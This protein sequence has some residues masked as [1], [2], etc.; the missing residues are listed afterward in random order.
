M[1]SAGK[2]FIHNDLIGHVTLF[3]LSLII[4]LAFIGLISVFRLIVGRFAGNL[5]IVNSIGRFEKLRIIVVLV[6]CICAFTRF[7]H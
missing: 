3:V 2:R 6:E 7:S 5:L 4:K 1:L